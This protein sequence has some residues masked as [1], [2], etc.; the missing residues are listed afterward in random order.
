MLKTENTNQV[1]NTQQIEDSEEI[2]SSQ[3]VQNNQKIEMSQL[4]LEQ[5]KK[6]DSG[7]QPSVA[8]FGDTV[9][10]VH[11][12]Q[13]YDT[14]WY[15]VGTI[16][17]E[18][19]NSIDWGESYE[20]GHGEYPNIS[21]SNG[22]IVEVHQSQNNSTLWYSIGSLNTK[23][24]NIEWNE[25][26]QYDTGI[27]PSI[28]I[29]GTKVVEVHKSENNDK[30]WYRVGTLNFVN[31]TQTIN[32]SSN[33]I[34]YGSG[35]TPK[36]SMNSNY[37][38]EV[39][40]SQNDNSLF[41]TVGKLDIES[42]TIKWGAIQNYDFGSAPDIS[43]NEM[44]SVV[45]MHQSQTNDVLWYYTAKLDTELETVDF[46]TSYKFEN[47][48]TPSVC[49]SSDYIIQSHKSQDEEALWSSCTFFAILNSEVLKCIFEEKSFP[50]SDKI[51]DLIGNDIIKNRENTIINRKIEKTITRS[52]TFE[53]SLTETLHTGVKSTFSLTIPFLA[54]VETEISVD[55]TLETQ[56]KWT[57]TLTEQYVF[58]ETIT[59]NPD[60]CVEVNWYIDI[61]D[62]LKIPFY[63][64]IRVNGY[65]GNRILTRD[66]LI[67]LLKRTGFTGKIDDTSI[68]DNEATV[69][70]QGNLCGSFGINTYTETKKIEEKDKD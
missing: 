16:S 40:Q 59:V 54:S 39:H 64:L 9:I 22:I 23:N 7:E 70:V 53:L 57:K 48:T 69:K 31:G 24:N 19:N 37:V 20:Y 65:Q 32:W 63:L 45:E 29:S 52:T 55:L 21:A 6:Y 38:I 2:K 12:S 49:S 34:E 51:K 3:Q 5:S 44:N 36:V 4:N 66:E 27:Q 25:A 46:E 11:K 35:L 47:G 61:I 10:E 15:H 68:K 43:I 50:N 58:N 14:L 13:N 41:Y 60:T 33:S 26:Q 30:L 8:I 17:N 67:N 28:T 42:N 18:E 62:N 1:E 56:K